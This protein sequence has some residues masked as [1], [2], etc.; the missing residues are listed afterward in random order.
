VRAK[1]ND[2]GFTLV[3]SVIACALLATA[4]LSIGHLSLTSIAQLSAA[5]HRTLATMLA[6]A[7]LEDLR[8]AAVPSAGGDTVDSL[9]QP[10]QQQTLWRFERRWSFASL[11][12]DTG[13]FTI[14][15]TPL[16]PEPGREIRLTGGW[17][18]KR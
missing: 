13:I 14:V 11:S 16:P 15:V 5:R 3:E 6:V 9:G 18:A 8:T 10:V 7:T 17:L 12:A 4:L 2:R 1:A